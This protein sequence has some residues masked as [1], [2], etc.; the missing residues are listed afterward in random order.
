MAEEEG[1]L[2]EGVPPHRGKLQETTEPGR[3]RA[4]TK[5]G[6]AIRPQTYT[7]MLANSFLASRDCRI[8]SLVSFRSE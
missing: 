4:V 6:L 3:A 7:L 5:A 1:D 8:S 2:G